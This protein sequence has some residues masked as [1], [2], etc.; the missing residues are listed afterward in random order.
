MRKSA[1]SLLLLAISLSWQHRVDAVF[2]NVEAATST[3]RVIERIRVTIDTESQNGVYTVTRDAPS[4]NRLT[5]YLDEDCELTASNDND[6]VFRQHGPHW[7]AESPITFNHF[8]VHCEEEDLP[9]YWGVT[10][11]D[12]GFSEDNF[13]ALQMGG[14]LPLPNI[15]AHAAG[16]AGKA[17]LA[18][19]DGEIGGGPDG[20]YSDGGSYQLSCA[21][22]LWVKNSNSPDDTCTLCTTCGAPDD[23]VC[24]NAVE[25]CGDITNISGKIICNSPAQECSNPGGAE[26]G[27]PCGNGDECCNGDCKANQQGGGGTCM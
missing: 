25:S 3:G 15:G 10:A 24:T 21:P 4:G 26:R 12:L 14:Y 7:G 13:P 2:A 20:C 8:T 5:W 22:G 16:N 23:V 19:R 6:V 1:L 17:G 27:S 9:R 11:N 18:K